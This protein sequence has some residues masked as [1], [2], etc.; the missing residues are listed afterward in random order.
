MKFVIL[1]K[2]SISKERAR[3]DSTATVT[4][5]ITI[6]NHQLGISVQLW[7]LVSIVST[8]KHFHDRFILKA[9]NTVGKQRQH[10]PERT[11]AAVTPF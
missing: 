11:S 5:S 2:L 10:L 1:L 4:L 6:N 9:L 3:T 7:L 8:Q